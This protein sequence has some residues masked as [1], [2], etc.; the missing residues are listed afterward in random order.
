MVCLAP[1]ALRDSVR[2][3]RLAGASVRPLNFTVRGHLVGL[4]K[5]RLAWQ[6]VWLG[7][8]AL[9]I[10]ITAPWRGGDGA[11]VV[12]VLLSALSFPLGLFVPACYSYFD[13]ARFPVLNSQSLPLLTMIAI[14]YVQ[15]FLLVPHLFRGVTSNNRWRG[16]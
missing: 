4:S 13:L 2:P 12:W 16:P 7:A 8:C 5:T 1:R 6:G 10:L 15:W 9:V 14:G 3:R 11:I